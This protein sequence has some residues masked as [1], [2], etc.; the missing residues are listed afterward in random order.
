MQDFIRGQ[1]AKLSQLA[2]TTTRFTIEMSAHS[3]A[4]SVF[5]F[6]CF[7]IDAKGQL[8][9][10]R[11]MVFFNQ[12]NAPDSAITL[13]NLADQSATFAFDLDKLP[14]SIARLVFTISVDGAGTMKQLDAS[15]L[16]LKADDQTLM[17]YPFS[18]ANFDKEGALMLAEIYRKENV[19]R[20]WAL[21][22]GFAGDLGALLAH[23]GGEVVEESV[24]MPIQTSIQTPPA[25][26]ISDSASL[27]APVNHAAT[28][29]AV[30]AVVAL[31]ELQKTVDQATTGATIRLPRGEYRGPIRIQRALTIEGEGAVIWAANGPVVA[32]A[33]ANVT[34]RVLQIEVTDGTSGGESDVALKVEGAAPSLQGVEVRGRVVGMNHETADDW[35]LPAAL[36]LGEFA[37]RAL[38]SW[39][40]TVKVPTDCQLKTSVSGLQIKPAQLGAGA[41][42]VEI[43]AN[44]IGPDTFLAGQIE[45]QHAGLVRPIP[46]SGR[47]ARADVNATVAQNKRVGGA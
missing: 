19:W 24:P 44:G 35:Q 11:F 16:T 38:N 13:E 2:P 27:S 5:D 39:R 28:P 15:E 10:D 43:V 41:H 25:P 22:Q 12:K 31:G 3:D 42:E 17:R 47:S 46:L 30:A 33:S 32:V 1:R 26:P 45:V 37:P 7:G 34:L 4:I 21:G 20:V 23:F 40:F 14:A 8:S 29:P 6:V 9:D 36:D 18:G